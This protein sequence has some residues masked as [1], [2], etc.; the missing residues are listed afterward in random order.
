M[1]L[2]LLRRGNRGFSNNNAW[3]RRRLILRS[4]GVPTNDGRFF[5]A[6]RGGDKDE[7]EEASLN[8]DVDGAS[9]S[10]VVAGKT[11]K[12]YMDLSKAK[13]SALVVTTT[14]AGYM[15]AGG[16]LSTMGIC[17]LGTA[18]C[19]SSAAAFNQV[20]EADRDALMKRTQQRPLV[21]ALQ[22]PN[23]AVMTPLHATVAATVWGAAGTSLLAYG[24][25]PTTAALGLG[26]IALYAGLYTYLKPRSVYNT[27]VGAVV[28]AIPPLMGWSAATGGNLL[29]VEAIL[30]GSTLY[31]WQMP[32]FF[33]LGYMHRVD[34][35]RGG[36]CM[37]PVQDGPKT[38]NLIVRYAWY[39][40]TVPFISTLTNVTTSMFCLEGLALNGYALYVAHRFQQDRTNANA[41]RVFLT[42]LWYLPSFL[43]L[44]L[45][46]SKTWDQKNN[47]DNALREAITQQLTRIR[48]QG[49]QLCLHETAIVQQPNDQESNNSGKM[50][51]PVV[52]A[53]KTSEITQKAVKATTQ[54]PTK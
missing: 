33:A 47:Q 45:L 17:C 21:V 32:H 52:V 3:S 49:R 24:C 25:D 41:R 5:S 2:V 13:L 50:A 43:V 27:W 14:A 54:V 12:A 6:T 34:Y 51:C 15:A 42:S 10:A 4:C 1:A 20:F 31:L 26:N 7:E 9:S 30:L 37:V 22:Q 53:N 11:V 36:F 48:Q 38:A 28:G 46:H 18:L 23:E 40:S 8:N 39:L 19:A 35:G 29:D 16:P 44:F